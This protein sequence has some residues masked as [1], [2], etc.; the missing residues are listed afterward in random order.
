MRIFATDHLTHLLCRHGTRPQR[1]GDAGRGEQHATPSL[2]GRATL[3]AV[4][5][6]MTT[7]VA[8]IEKL[9]PFLSEIVV[10]RRRRGVAVGQ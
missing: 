8:P 10:E 3:P 7:F 2:A 5:A 6:L 4:N 1:E 9:E